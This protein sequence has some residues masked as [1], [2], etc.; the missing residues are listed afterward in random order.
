V[1]A[2]RQRIAHHLH[3]HVIQRLFATGMHLQGTIDRSRPGL[4]A[5]RL[6]RTLSDL[7][8]AINE[9]RTAI[10]DL[11]AGRGDAVGFRQRI[12]AAVAD[13]TDHHDIVTTVRT[14]GPV[15]VIDDGLGAHA[16]S[17]ILEAVSNTVRHSGAT[18]LTVD[19]AVA[20][21]LDITITDDGCGISA[22][23]RRRSGLANM[24]SRAQKLGGDCH[25][26]SPPAGG[27]RVDWRVPLRNV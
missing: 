12:E 22:D 10:F 7:Q 6:N 8:T 2:E 5:D 15:S 27:T 14:S 21:E 1:L 4:I 3:D 11:Q 24:A 26:H 25:V 23:N 16:E 20:D 9:I 19:V 18:R 13:L 17:V